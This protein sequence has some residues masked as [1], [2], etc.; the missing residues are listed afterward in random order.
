MITGITI[1][2]LGALLAWGVSVLLPAIPLLTAAV[3][4]GI[5]VGQAPAAQRWL[6]GV[7]SSGIT[8]VSRHFVRIGI[9]LL[10]LKLSLL[11]IAELG[12]GTILTTVLIVV[13][14]FFGTVALGHLFKLSGHEPLLVATGFSICGVSAIGAMGAVVRARHTEQATPIA[15]VT[16][17]G[18]LA[19]GVLPI[20]WHPLGLSAD[21]FGY[22]VGASVHDVGQVVATAQVAGTTALAVAVVIKLTRVVM[23]APMVAAV[24]VAERRRIT[25]TAIIDTDVSVRPPIMPLFIIGFIAAVLLQTFI[26]LP[27]PV[28]AVTDIVQTALLATALFALGTAI[29]VRTLVTTGW[30]AFAVGLLSWAL[31][32]ALALGAVQ[33]T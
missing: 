31:I 25:Q 10:G 19:I 13:C 30:R 15:L 17:C 11:D 12:W 26:P 6:N 24:S 28:L 16:L 1:S 21:Q 8:F 32:A 23:L 29:R 14:T 5:I 4:L 27:D 20:L 2:V 3:A 7:F 33:L 18:T 9:V 22:W